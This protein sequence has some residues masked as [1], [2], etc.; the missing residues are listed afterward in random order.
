MTHDI[1]FQISEYDN[2]SLDVLERRNLAT[3]L[4]A[5]EEILDAFAA[6]YNEEYGSKDHDSID[7]L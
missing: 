1:P 6:S 4:L 2:D 5:D 3:K 7:T